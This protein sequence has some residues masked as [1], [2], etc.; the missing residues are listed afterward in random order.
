MN[1]R[2][3]DFPVAEKAA[4]EIVSFL[5]MFPQLTA[6]QQARVVRVLVIE[7]NRHN[8]RD[9]TQYLEGLGYRKVDE[10]RLRQDGAVF[11]NESGDSVFVYQSAA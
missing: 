10:A 4:A 3:G 7:R 1:Y 8:E 5:P 11:A 2:K 9:T 6:E